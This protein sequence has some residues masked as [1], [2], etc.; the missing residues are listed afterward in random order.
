[1]KRYLVLLLAAL[2]LPLWLLA[3]NYPYRSDLLWVARPDHADW[4]YKTGQKATVEIQL[5]RYGIPLD[6]IAVDY[7]LA[8]ELMPADKSGRVVLK[9]GKATIPVGTMKRPGFRD[10]R[11]TATVDGKTHKYHVKV[12]FSPEQIEPCTALPADFR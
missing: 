1:M 7:E 12:G 10:C 6:G 11:L 2:W 8:D 3:E 5:Y 9:E 4:L